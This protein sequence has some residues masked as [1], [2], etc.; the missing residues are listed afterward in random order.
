MTRPWNQIRKKL[1]S[2]IQINQILRPE[3]KKKNFQLK[4]IYKNNLSKPKMM[5]QAM[6]QFKSVFLKTKEKFKTRVIDIT[7]SIKSD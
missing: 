4:E 1:G 6:T 7:G 5:A 3:M 2:P